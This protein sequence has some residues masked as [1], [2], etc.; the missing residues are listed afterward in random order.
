MDQE[1]DKSKLIKS[2]IDETNNN[3][4]F[5]YSKQN[6]TKMLTKYQ[7]VLGFTLKNDRKKE[8]WTLKKS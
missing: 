2:W 4:R 1:H 7:T 6:M 3:K 5:N 8:T